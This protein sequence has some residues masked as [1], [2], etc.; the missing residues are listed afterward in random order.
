MEIAKEIKFNGITYRLMGNKRYYLSQSTKNE[1]RKNPKGLHVAIWEYYSKQQVPEGYIIHHKDGNYLNNDFSNLECISQK[2]HFKRHR[3]AKI[4]R[5]KSQEQIEHLE[6]IR[7][8]ATEWHKS[9][10]GSKWHKEHA[11]TT[12][13][14]AW[15]YRENKICA[16][17]NKEYIAKSPLSQYCSKPC[18]TKAYRTRKKQRLENL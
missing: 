11:K 14:K 9:S 6:K 3:Q 15:A 18:R 7:E 17:C 2:E 10:E 16:V 1:G 12:L 13:A 5:G 8:K 4:E